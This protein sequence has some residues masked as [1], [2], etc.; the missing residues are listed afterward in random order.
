MATYYINVFTR[1]A[2]GEVMAGC[3]S[4]NN[5]TVDGRLSFDAAVEVA[6]ENAKKECEFKNREY[7]G[8][9][10]KKSTRLDF[11]NATIVDCNEGE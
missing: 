3:G 9:A 2:N 5:F 6:R 7:L 1:S 4:F 11:S 10:I 8:F